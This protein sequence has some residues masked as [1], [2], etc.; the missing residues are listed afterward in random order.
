M[1]VEWYG[2]PDTPRFDTRELPERDGLL[3]VVPAAP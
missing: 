3:A 1:H 2:R